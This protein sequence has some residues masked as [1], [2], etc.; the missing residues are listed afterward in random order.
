MSKRNKKDNI[1]VSSNKLLIYQKEA[2]KETNQSMNWTRRNKVHN[3]PKIM[4]YI[5]FTEWHNGI[6][7]HEIMYKIVI[8]S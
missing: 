8:Q 1:M 2:Q 5:H 4:P 6:L 3:L 7:C